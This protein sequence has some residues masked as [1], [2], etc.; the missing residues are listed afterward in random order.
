MKYPSLLLAGFLACIVSCHKEE[1]LQTIDPGIV[2]YSGLPAATQTGVNTF[3]CEIGGEVWVPRVPILTITY[4][5]ITSTV[6]EKDN[7]GSGSVTC[8]LVDIEKQQDNRLQITFPPTYFQSVRNCDPTPG[9]F[10]QFRDSNGEL[11]QSNYHPSPENCVTITH[12]DTVQNIVSGVF[13]F[14][15]YNNATDLNDKISITDGRFD[16]KYAPQ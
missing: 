16:L 10:A 14:I 5:D 7:S 6:F 2:D 9:V 13:N 11:Y 12:I 3:G 4:T 8:Y 1:T 15:V